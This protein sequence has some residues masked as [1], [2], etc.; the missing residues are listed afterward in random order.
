MPLAA[1][2]VIRPAFL[3]TPPSAVGSLGDEAA[4]LAVQLEQDVRE[5]ERIALRALMPVKANG[6][7]AGL[8]AG[9]V[10]G[11]QQVK[12]WAL[13]MAL[14][15][16]GWVTKVG[17]CMWSAHLTKTSDENF[18]HLTDLIKSFDWLAK[19]VRRTYS[20]NG[21]HKLIFNDKLTAYPTLP[22]GRAGR[23][24]SDRTIEFGARESGRSGRGRVKVNR[25]TLDEWL[26]GTEAMKGGQVPT[27]GAAGDRYIRY[28]SSPGLLISEA[29]RKLRDRGRRGCVDPAHG[30][31]S[32]S[33]VEWTS[34]R[35]RLRRDERT[36]LLRIE[37]TLPE[38]A[39]PDCQHLAGL[40]EGCFLDDQ[41][42]IRSNNPAY[43]TARFDAEFREQERLTLSAQE[44]MRER[45][46]IWE[47]PPSGDD[48]ADNGLP[49]YADAVSDRG[50]A[51]PYTLGLEVS[52]DSKSAAIAIYGGGTVEVID[53]RIGKGITWVP[54]RVT[55]LR[56]KWS[57]GVAARKG[58]AAQLASL[59]PEDT[60]WIP[61]TE[62]PA[63]CMD[64]ARRINEGELTH[65]GQPSLD[66]A[67]GNAVRAWTGD[68]WR[69]SLGKSATGRGTDISPLLACTW[70]AHV[71]GG[72]VDRSTE[73]LLRSLGL[74]DE[75]VERALADDRA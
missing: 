17:R 31:P 70:A 21:N 59:L 72:G 15:H 30:D 52:A 51:A 22:G 73:A 71:G 48:E 55:E 24:R 37:R 38:C 10:C 14:I 27:M 1:P 26:Y 45:G 18:T 33:W 7:P 35:I 50:A 13:E 16:D 23:Q 6:M 41:D 39:D 2:D 67:V 5:E 60:T 64:L 9:I 69:W 8:E 3:W 29:L 65:R 57:A 42:L 63:A 53:Y 40:V 43:G 20:G 62:V 12:S 19:R 75:E 25:L 66:I 44:Y 47:D 36:G 11:R 68:V 28:G 74:S 58:P 56:T 54:A 4:E 32:L 49:G 46:G 61:A 34:E